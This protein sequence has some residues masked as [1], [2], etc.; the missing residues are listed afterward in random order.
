M[1]LGRRDVFPIQI[2]TLIRPCDP[3]ATKPAKTVK[4]PYLAVSEADIY[5]SA[6]FLARVTEEKCMML[7]SRHGCF[8]QP[9]S[10]RTVFCASQ[11]R[12][13]EESAKSRC[14]DS[15][16]QLLTR[17]TRES[18]I[19]EL[20]PYVT[21]YGDLWL[22]TEANGKALSEITK[23]GVGAMF[24]THYRQHRAEA[25]KAGSERRVGYSNLFLATI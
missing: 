22:W 18:H 17:R 11:E 14:A 8:A 16:P 3:V 6:S 19:S 23:A 25:R 2:Y 13:L 4:I 9:K 5:F 10:L 1:F 15:H 12:A 24:E 7:P 20:P 21:H